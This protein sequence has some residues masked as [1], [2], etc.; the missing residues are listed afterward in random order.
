MSS[1]RSPAGPEY[2]PSSVAEL[3]AAAAAAD[4]RP[5]LLL[6]RPKMPRPALEFRG[7]FGP[8]SSESAREFRRNP[9][10]SRRRAELS[11]FESAPEPRGDEGAEPPDESRATL[12]GAV[13]ATAEAT[14]LAGGTASSSSLSPSMTSSTQEGGTTTEVRA[15]E[16]RNGGVATA[17]TVTG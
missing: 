16:P 14:A 5:D 17:C 11:R 15:R 9:L 7:D 10:E 4:S 8:A 6:L 3:A 12:G 1:G 2:S 13:A